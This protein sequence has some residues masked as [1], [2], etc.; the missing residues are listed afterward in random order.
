MLP[1]RAAANCVNS[2]RSMGMKQNPC[3]TGL[4]PEKL[5]CRQKSGRFD[6]STNLMRHTAPLAKAV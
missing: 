1:R 6:A 4:Q 2:L 3:L 5:I